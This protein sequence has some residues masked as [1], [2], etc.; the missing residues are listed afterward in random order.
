MN[1]ETRVIGIPRINARVRFY[2]IAGIVISVESDLPIEDGT[3]HPK[4]SRFET[5][6]P[7]KDTISFR[8]HFTTTLPTLSG[9]AITFNEDSPWTVYEREDAWIYVAGRE[10]PDGPPFH[11][12]AVIR[13]DF[14]QVDIYSAD[15]EA[16]RQGGIPVLGLFPTDQILLSQIL[17]PRKAFYIHSS[18]VILDGSGL[19]F[20]GHSEAGKST[21][22]KMLK[23]RG[24]ILCDDRMIVRRWPDGFRIHGTWSHGEVP[25]VSSNSARLK[26]IFLLVKDTDNRAVRIDDRREILSSILDCLVK[27]FAPAAWWDRILPLVGF[28]SAEI[29][30]YKLHF[31]RSGAVIDIL[32]RL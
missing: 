15:S 4:F 7:G 28:L 23:D 27:P 6:G 29:P 10:A 31:D 30:F 25:I 21:M 20:I 18:G 26:G 12:Y 19:L 24:E 32:S 13:K 9:K 3:F 17:A 5:V 8:H 14:A 2:E 22:V 11:Q 16:Y 1:D